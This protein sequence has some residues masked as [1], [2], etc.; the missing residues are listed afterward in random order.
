VAAGFVLPGTVPV[1]VRLIRSAEARVAVP[2][3]RPILAAMTG[4]KSPILPGLDGSI[5]QRYP[6][7]RS[8]LCGLATSNKSGYLVYLQGN[9]LRLETKTWE[10]SGS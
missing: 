1:A 8:V 5:G 7:L 2:H 9:T 3:P 6:I 10:R 4:A